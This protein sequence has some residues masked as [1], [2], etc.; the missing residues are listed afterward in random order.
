MA[1]RYLASISCWY[2]TYTRSLRTSFAASGRTNVS[3]VVAI[4]AGKRDSDRMRDPEMRKD[5]GEMGP[6]ECGEFL[7][8]GPGSLAPDSGSQLSALTS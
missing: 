3:I 8:E 7:D 1:G 2:C 5:D 4:A 6:A